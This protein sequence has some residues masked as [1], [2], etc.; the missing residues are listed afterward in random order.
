MIGGLSKITQDVTPF[1]MFDGPGT[2]VG[3]NRVG[4]RRMGATSDEI[5]GVR[6]AYRVLCRESHSLFVARQL[7]EALPRT[8]Y[9]TAIVDFFTHDSRRGFHLRTRTAAGGSGHRKLL[10]SDAQLA[11]AGLEP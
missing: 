4:L 6:Q 8:R 2:V 1:F 11:D 5:D 10:S 9:L 3:I 7:L